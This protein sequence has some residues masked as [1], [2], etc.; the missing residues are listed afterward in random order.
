M[1][2]KFDLNQIR[3]C[4]AVIGSFFDVA[5]AITDMSTQIVAASAEQTQ[6]ASKLAELANRF[7]C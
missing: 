4:I 7:A 3:V 2:S 5:T 1:A 6:L